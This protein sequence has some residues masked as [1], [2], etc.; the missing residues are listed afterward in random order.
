MEGEF[1]H[2]LLNRES[3]DLKEQHMKT[4]F[5]TLVVVGAI[6][7]VAQAA[8]LPSRKAAAPYSIAPPPVWSGFYLGVNLGGGIPASG[9]SGGVIGGGQVGY[10]YQLLPLFI[11]GLETDIQGADV[12]GDG[13]R[14]SFGPPFGGSRS[15]GVNWFGTVRARVG[16]IAIS[17]ALLVYG[18][19]GLAYG[20]SD[21]VRTG[22]TAGGGVEWAFVPNWSAKLEYLYVDLGQDTNFAPHR[23]GDRA[24]NVVRAGVNYHFDPLIFLAQPKSF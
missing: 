6:S 20:G 4:I 14:R 17:P 19:G 2:S 5:R 18:A 22:W 3:R 15:R 12:G 10:N 9:T 24:F 23:N 16:T 7:G 1:E 11:A 8:D 21:A 13:G